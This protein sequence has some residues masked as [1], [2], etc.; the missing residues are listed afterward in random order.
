MTDHL[1]IIL[2]IV[3]ALPFIVA[4]LAMFL[5]PMFKHR[6]KG[7]WMVC[8]VAADGSGE[9]EFL[10]LYDDM[11]LWSK[12][13]EQAYQYRPLSMAKKEAD[14]FVADVAPLSRFMGQDK[15]KCTTNGKATWCAIAIRKR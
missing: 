15:A 3:V 12:K 11:V 14:A 8:R 10:S 1:P 13:P 2:T 4:L 6:E 5:L 7:P 9:M